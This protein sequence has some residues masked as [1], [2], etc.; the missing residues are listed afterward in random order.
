MTIYGRVQGV[1]FRENTKNKAQ[2]LGV[3]GKVKNQPNGS[4]YVDAE[5]EEDKLQELIDWCHHGPEAARVD[6]VDYEF[7]SDLKGYDSF[8]VEF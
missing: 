8:E 2:E 3:V 4:V 6:E 1:F 5:G 7:Q